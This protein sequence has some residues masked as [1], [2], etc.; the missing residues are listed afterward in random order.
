MENVK[1]T[2]NLIKNK[3][4]E[5]GKPGPSGGIRYMIYIVS[6]SFAEQQILLPLF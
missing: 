2:N 6:L 3:N 1:I 5:Q 4:Q